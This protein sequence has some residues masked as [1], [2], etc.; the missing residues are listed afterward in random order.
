MANVTVGPY[1]VDI[2]LLL[3]EDN[4]RLG[5]KPPGASRGCR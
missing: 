3:V 5:T 4:W 2:T 1:D